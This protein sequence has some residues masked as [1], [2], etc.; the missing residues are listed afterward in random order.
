MDFGTTRR[1]ERKRLTS[2]L[3]S[4]VQRAVLAAVACV[5][6]ITPHLARAQS[7]TATAG[8]GDTPTPTAAETPTATPT[9]PAAE[10]PTPTITDTPVDTATPTITGTPTVTPT[11]RR[12]CQCTFTCG[13]PPPPPNCTD[14]GCV[15]VENAVCNGGTGACEFVPTATVTPTP[16]LT[17]TLTPTPSLTP[18]LG[19]FAVG[20]Y[21]CYRAKGA[22]GEPKFVPIEGVSIADDF[23]SKDA[24]VVKPLYFCTPADKNNEGLQNPNDYMLCYRIR[25]SKPRFPKTN[26]STRNQFDEE[27]NLTL[28]AAQL[29]CVPSRRVNLPTATPTP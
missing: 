19:G 16:T 20:H 13:G 15:I 23:A 2:R 25:D 17:R 27:Q 22:P 26:V 5:I 29:L 18:T 7:P 11:P 12:C 24:K 14:V 28:V 6:L 21:K 3:R 1:F 10:S 4:L 9:A 8:G